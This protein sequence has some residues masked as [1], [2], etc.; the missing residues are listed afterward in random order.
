MGVLNGFVCLGSTQMNT[1]DTPTTGNANG[2]VAYIH[3]KHANLEQ[4]CPILSG[5]TYRSE[6]EAS[7]REQEK[8]P[9]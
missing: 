6:Q 2:P 9:G 5:S 8:T 3:N 1:L 7:S 4:A